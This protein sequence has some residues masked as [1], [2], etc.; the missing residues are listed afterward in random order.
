MQAAL[1][2][3]LKITTSVVFPV[4]GPPGT[5]GIDGTS[6]SLRRY[7]GVSRTGARE[8]RPAPGGD[9]GAV[10]ELPATGV[11]GLVTRL[12]PELLSLCR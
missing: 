5:I 6:D 12:D 10:F 1:L 2:S 11:R 9:A 3:G 4:P 7:G 8:A